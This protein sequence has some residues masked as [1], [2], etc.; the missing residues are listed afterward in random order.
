[1]KNEIVI[2]AQ[3]RHIAIS[4]AEQFEGYISSGN[5]TFHLYAHIPVDTDQPFFVEQKIKNIIDNGRLE[6]TE[7]MHHQIDGRSRV[8]I[9]LQR[10]YW[11]SMDAYS[12]GEYW[13]TGN[14]TTFH[15]ISGP[16]HV[17]DRTG[18]M[19]SWYLHGRHMPTF[20]SI[21]TATDKFDAFIQ[22]IKQNPGHP[23]ILSLITPGIIECSKEAEENIRQMYEALIS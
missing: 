20:S 11:Q 5:A 16:A 17:I 9:Q 10:N 13:R 14:A 18:G 6:F 3:N 7:V 21:L 12:Y 15:R 4:L 19:N 22:Y 8:Y 23:E 2:M 1:M